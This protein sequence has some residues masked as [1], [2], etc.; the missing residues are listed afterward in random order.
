MSYL[1]PPRP[2][3]KGNPLIEHVKDQYVTG[4]MSRLQFV[5]YSTLLGL[6]MSAAASFLAACG[7]GDGGGGGGG[8]GG[9]TTAK[10]DLSKA[11]RGGT[12]KIGSSIA[13]VDHPHRLSWIY[14]RNVLAQANEYLTFTD[15]KNITHPYLLEKWEASDDATEWTLT[16]R[17]GISFTDGSPLTMDDVVWNFES[18][19]DPETG[20]S[21][22]GI[23][24]PY[25]GT[26]GIEKRDDHT[27]VLTLK[28][29][30]ISIPEILFHYPAQI[31]K[32]NYEAPNIKGGQ[33]IAEVTVGTGP[34][35][36][37]QLDPGEG[38]R[39]VRNPNYWRKAPDGKP[40]PFF[41]EIVWTDLGTERS[42]YNA[43]LESG[44]VD[45]LYEAQP[46]QYQ[47]LQDDTGLNWR[48]VKTSETALMRMR[49]DV[50]PFTDVNVR[51]AFK[52]VQPRQEIANTGF[53]GAVDLGFD[54]HFAPANPDFV[55]RPI[56]D[57]DIEKA[58]Q[59][60]AESEAWQA[61]GNKPI[62][63]TTK[64]DT[65]YE[66]VYA[67][68][69][70]RAAKE[71]GINIELDTRPASEYW[72]KWNH[73]D[74]GVTGWAHRPLNTMLQG[75]AYSKEALPTKKAP[76]NWNETRWTNDEFLDLLAQANQT[77]DLEERL[78]HIG[79]ME[80]I[81]QNEAGI[82]VPWFFNL[83][84]VDATTIKNRPGHPSRYLLATE[85]WKTK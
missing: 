11:T 33:S 22:L 76:G 8:G 69:F 25:L 30:T 35:I 43:A 44:Q 51:T 17:K 66:P 52:L 15:E 68:V 32:R 82:G 38:A 83:F 79:R 36:V 2:D 18:W 4:K 29:P 46:E 41:D 65:R 13:E 62:K 37:K 28:Q 39:A 71:A 78:D 55:E 54:A 74:F 56:P 49:V 3:P 9:E 48:R 16:L 63:M 20:S 24:S 80:E 50:E 26:D 75:L 45:S 23:L 19:L 1:E 72:P 42:P 61:W 21:V 85:A 73:Y 77:V 5:R 7:G 60:L 40:L 59:L 27:I 58:K 10:A 64:N 12:Y 31:L 47:A 70:Q 53:F 67:E 84:D 57:Q 14:S 6:S 81:Q 34:F